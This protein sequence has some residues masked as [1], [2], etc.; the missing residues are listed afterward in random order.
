MA[1]NKRTWLGRQGTGLNKFSIGGASPVTI[2]NQPDSVT[3]VGDALSAGNL[4]DLEDRIEGA[5][6]D[7][8]TELDT[9][10]DEQDV[11]NLNNALT[12][13]DHRVSNLEQAHGSY[14]VSNYKD[15]SI[16][17][18]GKGKWCVVEGVEGVSRV[19]NQLMNKA[20][21]PASA[22]Y[23]NLSFTNNGDGSFT[24]SC[25][26]ALASDVTIPIESITPAKGAVSG[27]TYVFKG[28]A[29]NIR[30]GTGNGGASIDTGDGRVATITFGTSISM[31]FMVP[32]GTVI[33]SPITVTPMLTDLNVYFNTSD[34]SFLGATD[35]AKLATIQKDYPHLLTPSEYGTRIVDWTG[36][37]VRAV[38]RNL[39]DPAKLDALSSVTRSGDTWTATIPN[40]LN[41]TRVE[42]WS[43][44]SFKAG[45]QYYVS[46]KLACASD[47]TNAR[48]QINYTDGTSS[49][50][51]FVQGGT[52]AVTGG[53]STAGKTVA[54]ILFNYSSGTGNVTV[55][56]FIINQSDAQDGTYTPYHAPNTLSFPSTSLKSAG[57]VREKKL[58]NVEVE[59]DGQ[60][61][62]KSVKTNP[63][64]GNDLSTLNWITGGQRARTNGLR[65]LLKPPADNYVLGNYLCEGNYWQVTANTSLSMEGEYAVLTDGTVV[66]YSATNTPPTGM[67]YYELKTP[68]PDTYSD[69]IIDNTLLTEAYGRMS[70]VQTGTVVDG[71]ADLG[72]IT[73]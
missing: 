72:F 31:G 63:L 3:Q 33:S 42:G 68:N 70:T 1:Y 35:S 20:N 7:V 64:G 21:Y 46:A 28:G 43:G 51:P 61:V 16:T 58:L 67:F 14:V 24:F 53:L 11:T 17:P 59:I 29:T 56:E 60:K 49:T 22:T 40:W 50:T 19:A 48:I 10:A 12:A 45:Q 52:T 41:V 9:K 13:L 6:D 39:L 30:F 47:I 37:G 66:F 25:P 44:V 26:T 18:S 2:V 69:P 71:I 32:Q 57:S 65:N 38:S 62:Q 23:G 54:N 55:S 34:L 8:D 15:G 4:N 36:N 73:L 27:H 5:F